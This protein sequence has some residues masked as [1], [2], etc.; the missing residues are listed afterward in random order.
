[1]AIP[2]MAQVNTSSLHKLRES[3][4]NLWSDDPV[5]ISLWCVLANL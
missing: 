1:M 3:M 2:G 5:M 4:E